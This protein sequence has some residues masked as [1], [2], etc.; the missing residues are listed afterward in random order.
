MLLQVVSALC[1]LV[2]AL[3]Y[4]PRND[5]LNEQMSAQTNLPA[6]AVKGALTVASAVVIS[7][8]VE[9][10]WKILIDIQK[11]EEWNPSL[12]FIQIID[13]NKTPLPPA[14]QFLEVGASIKV[15]LMGTPSLDPS[16]QPTGVVE[17]VS[18]VDDAHHRWSYRSHSTGP[19]F[20]AE[21]AFAV[22]QSQTDPEK[23]VLE[24]RHIVGGA[25]ARLVGLLM[26]ARLKVAQVE[27]GKALKARAERTAS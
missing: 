21:R 25:F 1:V 2:C 17:L 11:Y 18:A 7:A 24:M 23:T 10:V 15:G 5:Y 13:A 3:L 19:M 26:G 22:S 6:P 8:P 12:R 14:Q 16:V 20:R 4:L 27:M 9:A